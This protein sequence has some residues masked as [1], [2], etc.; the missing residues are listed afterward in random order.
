MNNEASPESTVAKSSAD[1]FDIPSSKIQAMLERADSTKTAADI[2]I[3]ENARVPV[4]Q[5]E[6]VFRI[7]REKLSKKVGEAYNGVK[8]FEDKLGFAADGIAFLETAQTLKAPDAVLTD[9]SKKAKQQHKDLQDVLEKEKFVPKSKFLK[10]LKDDLKKMD[11]EGNAK[12][13]AFYLKELSKHMNT[14]AETKFDMTQL[15]SGIHSLR[16]DMRWIQLYSVASQGLVTLD[17]GSCKYPAYAAT[18]VPTGALKYMPPETKDVPNG[19]VCK[20]TW[21]L[22]AGAVEFVDNMGK[23]KELGQTI[24]TLAV[25]YRDSG[26]AASREDAKKLAEALVKKSASSFD[27]FEKAKEHYAQAQKNNLFVELNAQFKACRR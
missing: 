19:G 11:W 22:F 1:R 13:D 5:L 16:R 14:I 17:K 6:A 26:V 10:D 27:P 18:V 21:C 3:Q 9:L 4:F 15:E 25:S 8:A 2:L 7:Y 20:I 23:V 24:E 12:E